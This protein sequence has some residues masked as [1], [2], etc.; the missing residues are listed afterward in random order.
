[1]AVS[2]PVLQSI[3]LLLLY[4]ACLPVSAARPP[5]II[6]ILADDIGAEAVGAYGG[7]SFKTPRLDQMASEGLR[8]EHGH[9]Q[10]LCTPSRVKLMTGQFNFRNYQHFAYLDAS[11]NTFAHLL[12][13][14]GYVTGVIG[15]WQLFDNRFQD[16]EGALPADAGFESYVLWQLKAEQR[17]SRYWSPLIDHNGDV[18]QY[19]DGIFGPDVLNTAARDFIQANRSKPFFL[20]YPMVLPH[21]PFVNTP[22]M[23]SLTADDQQLF[24]AMIAYMDKLVGNVIDTVKASGLADNTV[25]I[26][27]GDNGTDQDIVSR[28][29]GAEIQGA[30]GKTLNN[31]T[32]VPFLLWAPGRIAPRVSTSLVN[33]ADILPTLADLA[34]A[35]LPGSTPPDGMSLVPLFERDT[36]LNRE[37]LFIHYDPRWPTGRPARY[38]FDRRWKYYE[39]GRFY[40]MQSDPLEQQ[41][42]A[43]GNLGR[44]GL[45]AYRALQSRVRAMEGKFASGE[46][47]RPAVA[48]VLVGAALLISVLVLVWAFRLVRRMPD[49]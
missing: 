9:A 15:K 4:C 14:A 11:E 29:R 48:F 30:K 33:L 5:N 12:S 27:L 19:G 43:A 35:A 40:D 31:G 13:D 26:F 45:T 16:I 23:R 6:L 20:Y 25:V 22:D 3:V 38:A 10:P 37:N 17:G 2:R 46:R 7:E 41:S 47:W 32:R 49:S 24:A 18:R 8:L 42:I 44:E 28:Y 34:G 36:E 39:D 1:M 21:S